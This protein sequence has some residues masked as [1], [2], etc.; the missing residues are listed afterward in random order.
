MRKDKQKEIIFTYTI[1]KKQ[2]KIQ[3]NLEIFKKRW[4]N[5]HEILTYSLDTCQLSKRIGGI[6]RLL[7]CNVSKEKHTGTEH[8]KWVKQIEV[9][10]IDIHTAKRP[11]CSVKKRR[12]PLFYGIGNISKLRREGRSQRNGVRSMLRGTGPLDVHFV[13]PVEE[14]ERKKEKKKSLSKNNECVKM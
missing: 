5:V 14:G 3:N 1:Y 4:Y 9:C 10:A 8:E 13:E 6:C 7:I 12:W 2:L 11:F